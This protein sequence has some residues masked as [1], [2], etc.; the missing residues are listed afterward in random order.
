VRSTHSPGC[1]I[2]LGCLLLA[3]CGTGSSPSPAP[4]TT[5]AAAPLRTL[6]VQAPLSGPAADQGRAMVDA[7]RLV[8]AQA[9][10]LAG[11]ARLQVRTLDDGGGR[12]ATDPARC[13]DNAARAAADPRALA[14]IGT[15][16]L[17]CSERALRVLRPAGLMLVSPLNA[18]DN[19][20]G[21]LRLA[22]TLGDQGGAAAQLAN[23][24]GATRVTI[25]SQRRGA[26]TAF[27]TG[28]ASAAAASGIAPVSQLDA[29]TASTRVLVDQLQA[30]RTQVVALAGSPGAWA[31]DLL[32]ALALLPA[33]VRPTVVAPQVFDTLAFLDGSG[34]AAEGVRVISRL[35]PAEEL[36]GSARSFA[37][38]YADL[39]GQPPP[40]AVY[41]ADAA[42][43][44]LEAARGG[45]ASRAAMAGALAALPAHDALLGRWASTPTGGITPRRLA[46]LVVAGGTFRVERVVSVAEPLPA[47]GDVK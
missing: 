2:L 11:P 31:T 39:H 21:A 38:A 29:S 22:P 44:V 26:A 13:A 42:Q 46:V 33:A 30:T 17:A 3:G 45:A 40:V 19:L 6:Y 18:A 5:A 23:A 4:T 16:E 36:G 32:A 47:S 28:L 24:L 1:A 35:V 27:A 14:V 12:T 7:V 41:A 43:A 9:G 10:G 37:G 8:I 20:P 15:Y 25:V 34:A